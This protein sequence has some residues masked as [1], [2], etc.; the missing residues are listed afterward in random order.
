MHIQQTFTPP[1]PDHRPTPE[2]MERYRDAT[3]RFIFDT[4]TVD[5]IDHRR[6]RDPKTGVSVSAPAAT[7]ERQAAAL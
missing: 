4:V 5:G 2:P 3:P 6:I 7:I 1:P